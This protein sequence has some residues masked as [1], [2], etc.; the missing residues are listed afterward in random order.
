[1]RPPPTQRLGGELG[2]IMIDPHAD[3]TFVGRLV[4]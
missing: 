2:R 3:P 1:V 4:V